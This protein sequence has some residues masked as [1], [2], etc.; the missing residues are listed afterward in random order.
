[1]IKME[2]MRYRDYL[3]TSGNMQSYSLKKISRPYLNIQ[4]GITKLILL[5]EK[6]HY[7][8]LYIVVMNQN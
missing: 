3:T 1:M 7:L 5:L 6:N 4:I 8:G 2:I